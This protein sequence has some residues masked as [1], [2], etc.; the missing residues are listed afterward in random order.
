MAQADKERWDDKYLDKKIAQHLSTPTQL[1]KDYAHLAKGKQAL[2]IACGIGRHSKYLVSLGFSVD[3]LDISSVAIAQLQG[4]EHIDAKEVDFDTYTL[5]KEK[6][7]LIVCTY[8]L[9]RKLFPQMIA[10]LKTDGII[11]FETF[12][13]DE[14]NENSPSNPTFLLNKGELESY[15]SKTCKLVHMKEWIDVDYK[16]NEVMKASMVA[17]K[18]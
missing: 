13:H 15:F 11:I 1:V 8:F 16:G 3:A 2:D 10:A 7:D 4:L 18:K 9:E 17:R 12:V 6:Y 5:E 14:H